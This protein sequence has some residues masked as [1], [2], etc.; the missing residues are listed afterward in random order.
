MRTDLTT[1]PERIPAPPKA[2]W[3]P[4]P[5]H[6]APAPCGGPRCQRAIFKATNPRTGRTNPV[7]CDVEGGQRPRKGNIEELPALEG[8]PRYGLGV[9]HFQT[10]VD[11]EMFSQR[12]KPRSRT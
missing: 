12:N 5:P 11:A 8:L 3:I 1:I 2:V 9:S 7:D 6:C 4:V 10:C